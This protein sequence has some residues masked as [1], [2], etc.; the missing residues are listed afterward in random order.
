MSNDSEWIEFVPLVGKHELAKLL[1]DAKGFLFPSFEPF[2]IAP[3]EAL[4]AGCPVIAFGEGGAQDYV[5]DGE[6]GVLFPRQTVKSLSDAIVRFEKM[7][8]DSAKVAK[9][10]KKFSAERF[11]KEMKKYVDKKVN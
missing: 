1:T 5:V 4:A 2:G 6:N 7:R 8:F 3:V 9:S 10:A 11:D